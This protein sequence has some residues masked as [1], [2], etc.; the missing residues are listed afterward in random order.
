VAGLPD[1]A[2]AAGIQADPLNIAS[3]TARIPVAGPVVV[4]DIQGITGKK[5]GVAKAVEPGRVGEELIRAS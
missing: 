4:A 1:C 2:G 3:E 5:Q